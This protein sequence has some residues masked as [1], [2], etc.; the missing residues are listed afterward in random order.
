[1]ERFALHAPIFTSSFSMCKIAL[2]LCSFIIY[3][4]KATSSFIRCLITLVCIL[5]SDIDHHSNILPGNDFQQ[6]SFFVHVNNNDGQFVFLTEPKYGSVH[7]LE[8]DVCS[9]W[10]G[11]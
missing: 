9:F 3:R 4:I 6:I 10:G 2:F 11:L 7:H 8:G 1:M 5:V